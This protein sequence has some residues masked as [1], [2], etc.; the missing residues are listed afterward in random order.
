MFFTT[1][2]R[3]LDNIWM[4]FAALMTCLI[5]LFNKEFMGFLDKKLHFEVISTKQLFYKKFDFWF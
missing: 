4:N 3:Y 1:M 5:T 2:F